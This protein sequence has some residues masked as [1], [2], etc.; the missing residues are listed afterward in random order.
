MSKLK[1]FNANDR[2]DI[3]AMVERGLV[4]HGALVARFEDAID[5]NVMDARAEDFPRY[6]RN[7]NAVERDDFFLPPTTIELPSWIDDG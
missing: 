5:A 6:V 1:R 7:L 4:P 3:R 2:D